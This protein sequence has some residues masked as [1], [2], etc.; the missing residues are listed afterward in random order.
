MIELPDRWSSVL[1]VTQ[2]LVRDERKFVSS[3][4][5]KRKTE[6]AGLATLVH[7]GRSYVS[8]RLSQSRPLQKPDCAGTLQ[9]PPISFSL[10]TRGAIW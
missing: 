7:V 9:T 1:A 6:L 3:G 4:S 2:S 5:W 8:P 10:V